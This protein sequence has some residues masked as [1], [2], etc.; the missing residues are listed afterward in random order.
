MPGLVERIMAS[1][2]TFWRICMKIRKIFLWL[3]FALA[4]RAAVEP[5]AAIAQK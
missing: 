4:D 2:L 5:M 3:A 1:F